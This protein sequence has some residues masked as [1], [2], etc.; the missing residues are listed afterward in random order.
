MPE[1]RCSHNNG[2]C[3]HLCESNRGRTKCSCRRGFK[4]QSDKRSCTDVDECQ[5]RSSGCS[6]NCINTWGSYKCQCH[7]GYQLGTDQKSCYRKS[8]EFIFIRN[9]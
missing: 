8:V 4:L 9:S 7:S 3:E 1:D 6:H 2:G 5:D